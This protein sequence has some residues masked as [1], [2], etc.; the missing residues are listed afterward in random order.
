MEN[1]KTK[2][3]T[4]N[5]VFDEFYPRIKAFQMN[6]A[7]SLYIDG[8]IVV[9][10]TDVTLR[11]KLWLRDHTIQMK[12][13]KYWEVNIK[14]FVDYFLK[15]QMPDDSF[16]DFIWKGSGKASI[17]NIRV[18]N[19]ADVEYHMVDAVYKIWQASGDDDWMVS[20]IERIEKGLNYSLNNPKRW[21]EEY[22]L[23]K[24]PF[25][26]DTWD[27]EYLEGGSNRDGIDNIKERVAE[28]GRIFYKISERTKFCIMHGDNSGV[29]NS[30]KL[31]AKIFAYTGDNKKKDYWESKAEEI[32]IQMNKVCWNGT[33]YTHQV[34]IDPVEIPG[35]DE[36]KQLSL[37]NTYDINRGVASHE[38]AVS[39]IKEYLRR[40]ETVDSFA[41][42]FTIDPPFP[43]GMYAGTGGEKA[44]E[45]INGSIMPLVGGELSRACFE[46]GFEKYGL[47][48]LLRYEK[49]IR[50]TGESSLWYYR[51]GTPGEEN[52]T[53]TDGWGAS[54]MLY[55]FMEGLVGIEDRSKLYEEVNLSP[56]WAITGEKRVSVTVGYGAS[57]AYFHYEY[58]IDESEK[59]IR[60]NCNGSGGNIV[61]HILLPE[62][63]KASKVVVNNQAVSF[64]NEVIEESNYVN[65]RGPI[66]SQ[67]KIDFVG[68]VKK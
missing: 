37:S 23:V 29:Y 36:S 9:G 41:E 26:I 35:V 28:D 2:I 34:H 39:I 3:T 43:D 25:T 21:S 62:K 50:E 54:A 4:G 57:N 32:K 15:K 45:Y 58:R 48:I 24:R 19:E 59:D 56:R 55:G 18:D 53:S 68:K 60:V 33:F 6:G 40:K 10:Y 30:C 51:N 42:W 12:G 31:L 46:H 5:P 1:D 8:N 63:T 65:F 14:N 38:Q 49:I 20:H 67:A 61:F 66:N 47:D 44:G 17:E 64:E 27:F 16:Y 13:Y 7:V 52:S 11:K 22:H